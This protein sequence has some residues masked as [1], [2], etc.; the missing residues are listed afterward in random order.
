MHTFKKRLPKWIE[1]KTPFSFSRVNAQNVLAFTE[2]HECHVRHVLRHCW[3][4]SPHKI[5]L[6][7]SCSRHFVSSSTARAYTVCTLSDSSSGHMRVTWEI[8]F[9]VSLWALDVYCHGKNGP[10]Q[11][12]Y[13]GPNLAALFG[14]APNLAAIFGPTGQY[15]AARFGPRV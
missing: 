14:L 7:A 3:Q 9:I 13:R 11:I 15:I 12:W 10:A 1:T 5:F 6:R 8:N 4:S 2:S